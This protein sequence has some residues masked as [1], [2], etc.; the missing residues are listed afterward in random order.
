MF[1]GAFF[2]GGR[3]SAVLCFDDLAGMMAFCGLR[4]GDATRW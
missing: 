1:H 3:V 4:R 2:V